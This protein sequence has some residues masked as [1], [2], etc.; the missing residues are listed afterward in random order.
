MCSRRFR[1]SLDPQSGS[2]YC[3]Y[4]RVFAFDRA[5]ALVGS[6]RWRTYPPGRVSRRVGVPE[7]DPVEIDRLGLGAP[8]TINAEPWLCVDERHSI[9]AGAV[10]TIGHGSLVSAA[11][12]TIEPNVDPAAGVMGGIEAHLHR[13]PDLS[14]QL[15]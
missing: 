8:V 6:A 13:G 15:A 3:P 5:V 14:R 9:A 1:D 4:G 7:H 11:E 12:R 10:V 2:R